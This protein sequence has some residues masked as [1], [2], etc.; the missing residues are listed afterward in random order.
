MCT[1]HDNP[2]PG[3]FHAL[4]LRLFAG[5]LHRRYARIKRRL[6]SGLPGTVVELGPGAGAN[7]RYYRPGTRVIAIEPDTRMHPTLREQAE[8]H[9]IAVDIRGLRGESLNLAT[10]SVDAV[11]A[12]LVLC[13]VESPAQVVAEVLRVLRPG[14][15]FVF[16]EHIAAPEGTLLRWIQRLLRRPWRWLFD[17]CVL[18]R[19]TEAELRRAGFRDVELERFSW[20]SIFFPVRSQICGVARA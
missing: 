9:G 2:V 11:V 13:T 12:T 4:F 18:D 8:R 10:D 6:F 5:Y 15:R 3:R 7:F 19:D 16:V 14:G 1:T 20:R 17:G